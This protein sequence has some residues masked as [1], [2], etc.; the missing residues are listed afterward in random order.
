[1]TGTVSLACQYRQAWCQARAVTL[2]LIAVVLC[3]CLRAVEDVP[4]P[5]V[6]EAGHPIWIVDHGWHTGLVLPVSDLPAGDWPERRDFPSAR[7]LEVAWGDREFYMTPDAGLGLAVKAALLSRGSVLHVVGLDRPVSEY[8]AGIEVVELRLS[9]AG[10][11]ALG[12]FIGA[13]HARGDQARAARLG[14][15][16]YGDSAFYSAEGRYS[17]LNTCNT[18]TAA[19]LRAAGCPADPARTVTA[20]GMMQQV[21]GMRCGAL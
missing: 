17:L 21:R 9:R 20:G 7:F 18:W 6:A 2:L 10:L 14:P 3:G 5:A 19:A 15:G 12:R 13:A 4:P 11:D 16:L 1:M 8:F